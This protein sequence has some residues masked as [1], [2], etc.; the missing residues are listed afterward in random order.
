MAKQKK[1][2]V[3]DMLQ[4]VSPY[5]IDCTLEDLQTKVNRWVTEYGRDARL[6]WDPHHYESYNPDPSPRFRIMADREETDEEYKVRIETERVQKAIIEAREL[7]E[8]E[9]LQKKFNK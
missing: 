6:E 4:D 2:I 8:L 1:K 5:D 7:A 9:R 3:R